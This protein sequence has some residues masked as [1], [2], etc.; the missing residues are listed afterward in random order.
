MKNIYKKIVL[1][2]LASFTAPSLYSSSS[3]SYTNSWGLAFKNPNDVLEYVKQFLPASPIILE[4]GAHLGEDTVNM[5]A[6]WPNATMHIFEP[7]P[8][9]FKALRKNLK[10]VKGAYCYPVALSNHGGTADFYINP[11]NP[12]ASSINAPVHWNAN[13][14]EK[15]PVQIHCMTLDTWA[16][17]YDISHVD[18]MWL[19]MEGHEL[20]ALSHAEKILPSVKAI[21]TEISFIPVRIGSSS[22]DALKNF[23]EGYGFAQ[24]WKWEVGNGYGDA[25]FVRKDLLP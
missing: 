23:L 3:V 20:Y 7:L 24:V 18:F 12:G 15:K 1:L 16:D 14:F 19:D 4:A 25:L 22:H 9:S 21:Y 10:Y 13:E 6:I 8:Q 11:G 5:K 17:L 2:T